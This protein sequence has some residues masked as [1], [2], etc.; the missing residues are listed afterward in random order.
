[1]ILIN[2]RP[3]TH[4]FNNGKEFYIY[5]YKAKTEIVFQLES[6]FAPYV[7]S[8][9]FSI[10]VSSELILCRKQGIQYYCSKNNN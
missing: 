9:F 2:Q 5:I 10:F 4:N 3:I 8:M 6:N 7:P 1:M